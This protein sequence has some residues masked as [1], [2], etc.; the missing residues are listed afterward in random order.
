MSSNNNEFMTWNFFDRTDLKS[1]APQQKFV[2]NSDFQNLLHYFLIE[3]SFKVLGNFRAGFS[4]NM[5]PI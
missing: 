3:S 1:E 4:S 5:K 2:L